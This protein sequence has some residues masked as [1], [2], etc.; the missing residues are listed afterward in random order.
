MGDAG[1]LAAIDA[2]ASTCPWRESQFAFTDQHSSDSRGTEFAQKVIVAQGDT[3]LCGFI[4]FSRVLDE[5]EILNV[6]VHPECQGE[7]VARSLLTA[8]LASMQSAGVKRCLLE[9]RESNRAARSLYR[10]FDF[11]LDGVRKKYY[12]TNTGREDALLMSKLLLEVAG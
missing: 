11:Q 8:A 1:L 4:A 9:V 2:A 6:A 10:S 3:S 7:G 12:P 5:G